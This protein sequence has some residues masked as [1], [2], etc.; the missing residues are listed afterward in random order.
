MATVWQTIE[1]CVE[2]PAE[3]GPGPT[4]LPHCG[5]AARE[6]INSHHRADRKLVGNDEGGCC[7][8]SIW[9]ITELST[10]LP[11][12]TEP[13]RTVPTLLGSY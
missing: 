1:L 7:M 11:A 6:R 2:L 12:E 5:A 13:G 10:Y 4:V 8:A 3:E 9:Q